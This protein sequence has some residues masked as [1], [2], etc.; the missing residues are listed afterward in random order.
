MN[1]KQKIY[2]E[3]EILELA[4]AIRKNE[5]S[6]KWLL[7]NQCMEL[8]ALTDIL[9]H[10]KANANEWLKK[11]K[12]ELLCAFVSALEGDKNSLLLLAKN[13]CNEWA[14]VANAVRN[15]EE[16]A[17]SWLLKNNFKHFAALAIALKDRSSGSG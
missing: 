9:V 1:P 8:A 13:G 6:F 16:D 11:N 3:E 14:A 2:S 5:T 15:N 10:G 17:F 12:Q 7:D 4:E